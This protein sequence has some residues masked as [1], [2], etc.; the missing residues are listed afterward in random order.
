VH[1]LPYSERGRHRQMH[2]MR[3]A[4]SLWLGGKHLVSELH[5]GESQIPGHVRILR[6]AAE[7]VSHISTRVLALGSIRWLRR[8]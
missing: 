4:F 7:E 1:D 3:K 8:I 5:E 6:G 2:G